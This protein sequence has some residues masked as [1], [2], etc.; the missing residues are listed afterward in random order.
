MAEGL[1]KIS[2][3][4]DPVGESVR[5]WTLDNGLKIEEVR[6]PIGVIAMIFVLPRKESRSRCTGS[7]AVMITG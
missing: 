6:V 1:I 4:T 3:F 7:T 2:E 5:G